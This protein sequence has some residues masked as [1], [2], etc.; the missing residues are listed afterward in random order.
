[1]VSVAV[2]LHVYLL[3]KRLQTNAP[4]PH[5]QPLPCLLLF[6]LVM[7]QKSYLSF[8]A[9]AVIWKCSR[10]LQYCPLFV[11]LRFCPLQGSKTFPA[12]VTRPCFGS[13]P[14]EDRL[15]ATAMGIIVLLLLV[16]CLVFVWGL[17]RSSPDRV[18]GPYRWKTDCVLH[19]SVYLCCWL[20]VWFL[21]GDFSSKSSQSL[22]NGPKSQ[23]KF[24]VKG[25]VRVPE[26]QP[27][28]TQ[29]NLLPLVTKPIILFISV[30]PSSHY[31]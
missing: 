25:E 6:V 17:Q 3:A 20:A 24:F 4:P 28:T 19:I 12:F 29:F 27:F 8:G 18:L 16:S 15:C 21:C 31:P 11:R 30:F 10:L 26:E 5:P 2:E 9:S 7:F 23:N 22:S 14:M 1:M 13:L